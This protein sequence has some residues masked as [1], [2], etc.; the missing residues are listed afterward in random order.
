VELHLPV[1]CFGTFSSF[2]LTIYFIYAGIHT[3]PEN[4][5]IKSDQFKLGDFGLVSKITNHSDV[6]EGDSRYM[7]M[8][9]LSGDHDD[10][11]KV[12]IFCAITYI[13]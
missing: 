5:F 12:G 1:P 2:L 4:I 11:T 8:E 6:E 13:A 10:L 7:S 9:L 3:Q